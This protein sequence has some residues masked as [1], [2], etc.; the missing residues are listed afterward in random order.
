MLVNLSLTFFFFLLLPEKNGMEISLKFYFF[1]ITWKQL[2]DFR[3]VD[4]SD[5]VSSTTS[6]QARKGWWIGWDTDSAQTEHHS[7]EEAADQES[8]PEQER[9]AADRPSSGSFL[10]ELGRGKRNLD[11]GGSGRMGNC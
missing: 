10:S 5:D 8:L 1:N 3:F 11:K 6:K 9:K 2:I 4:F 7:S